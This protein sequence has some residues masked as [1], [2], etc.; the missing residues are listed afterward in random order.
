MT[1]QVPM[2]VH[3]VQDTMMTM[4]VKIGEATVAAQVPVI[5]I[6]LI[7]ESGQHGTH[8]YR[9][10]TPEEKDYARQT[11]VQGQTYILNL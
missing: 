10:R 6:E 5:E 11:F 2:L 1:R 9:F 8:V 3:R 4:P 7:D